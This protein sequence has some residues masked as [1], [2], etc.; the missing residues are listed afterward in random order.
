MART[1]LQPEADKIHSP[2][3]NP[4]NDL[5]S[6]MNSNSR[7]TRFHNKVKHNE[8]NSWKHGVQRQA[9][10]PVYYLISCNTVSHLK[11]EHTRIS[12]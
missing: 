3:S 2:V 5:S 6:K 1:S 4:V 12:E 9:F 8:M 7:D 10:F 11:K